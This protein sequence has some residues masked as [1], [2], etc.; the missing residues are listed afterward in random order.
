MSDLRPTP[1]CRLP[2][3]E[4]TQRRFTE[5]EMRA[6]ERDAK[7]GLVAT[8]DGGGLP[9]L[10]LIT[11]IQA[12]DPT[13]LMYG[14]FC[15]GL[16][17]THVKEN[18]RTGFLIMSPEKELWR[19]KALWTHEAKSGEDYETYNKKPMFRY[20]SY[21]GIHTVHYLDL[22]TCGGKEK[23]DVPRIALGSLITML[24]R[25]LARTHP[26]R[27]RQ[28]ER[29]LKPWAEA[30]IAK[31]GTLKFL[32]Y[33]GGDG[34]PVIVPVVPCQ[35]VDSRRLVFAPTVYRREL[36]AVPTGTRIAVFA[37]N[38]QME[39]VLVRG[40]FAGYRRYVGPPVGIIDIDWV[41]N[42]MPPKQGTIYPPNPALSSA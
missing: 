41:Y 31:P 35:T 20:N 26:A 15:E 2:K 4:G 37:L 36:A 39:S 16:S 30:H 6:F 8:V 1:E 27:S 34:Y 12:R 14:Q 32:S 28:P 23:A 19:G 21:F 5:Q 29:I 11:S 38:L 3:G 22:V 13:H 17:K 25:H 33:V 18:A 10:T 42:S 40:V 9:H 7:I 24:S